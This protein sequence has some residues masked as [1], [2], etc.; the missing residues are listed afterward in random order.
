MLL[1]LLHAVRT[2]RETTFMLDISIRSDQASSR[3]AENNNMTVAPV[4][5]V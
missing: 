5:K 3:S 2:L 1:L 4:G